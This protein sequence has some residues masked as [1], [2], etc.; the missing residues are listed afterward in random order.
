VCVCAC[1]CVCVPVWLSAF[2]QRNGLRNFRATH[3]RRCSRS[4]EQQNPSSNNACVARTRTQSA[5]ARND[6]S[7]EREARRTVLCA[8][9]KRTQA[10]DTP[11]QAHTAT[12]QSARCTHEC[13]T[14]ARHTF[15]SVVARGCAEPFVCVA[16]AVDNGGAPGVDDA[17]R[18]FCSLGGI[19]LLPVGEEQPTPCITREGRARTG[20][21]IGKHSSM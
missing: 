12:P 8:R 18:C 6:R 1:V 7:S 19:G 16:D 17:C 9:A 20:R 14:H 4:A 3:R 5:N 21:R 10:H 2:A 11:T 15:G 13:T